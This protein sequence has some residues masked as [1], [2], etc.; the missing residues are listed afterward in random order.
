V[1]LTARSARLCHRRPAEHRGRLFTR[2]CRDD[3]CSVGLLERD[4]GPVDPVLSGT[5]GSKRR[6]D[7]LDSLGFGRAHALPFLLVCCRDLARQRQDEAPVI[8]DFPGRCLALEQ[9]HRVGAARPDRHPHRSANALLI[10]DLPP[11]G[12]RSS[13]R[14]PAL[15]L[16]EKTCKQSLSISD[17]AQMHK[18]PVMVN[19]QC[20]ARR[21]PGAGPRPRRWAGP[22]RTRSST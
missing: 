15:S 10:S 8:I 9:C 3:D 2:P 12:T 11:P 14:H 7:L 5:R 20:A 4:F 1:A 19:L 16:P 17:P 21:R 13:S 22:R 18:R 6:C